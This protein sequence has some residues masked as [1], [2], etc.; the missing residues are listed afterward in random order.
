MDSIRDTYP[1]AV[2]ACPALLELETKHLPGI[3]NQLGH[4]RKV[5]ILD[6]SAVTDSRPPKTLPKDTDPFFGYPI[7]AQPRKIP[8]DKSPWDKTRH[9]WKMCLAIDSEVSFDRKKKSPVRRPVFTFGYIWSDT[10]EP[11]RGEDL[12]YVKSINLPKNVDNIRINPDRHPVDGLQ[13]TWTD[14]KGKKQY[15]YTAEHIRS[16]HLRKYQRILTFEEAIAKIDNKVGRDLVSPDKKIREN[17][18]LIYLLGRTGLHLGNESTKTDIK[19]F[20]VATAL[21][22]HA[23]VKLN[24]NGSKSA[25]LNYIGP[26]GRLIYKTLLDGN[27]AAIIAH[28]KAGKNPDDR[29]FANTTSNDAA[30]YMKDI[31]GGYTPKDFRVYRATLLALGEV[32]KRK[33]VYASSEREFRRW[34]NSAGKIVARQLGTSTRNAV[35]NLISPQVWSAWRQKDWD[36]WVPKSVQ[37]TGD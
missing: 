23:S 5:K 6:D 21:A 11:V 31:S 10:K 15:G 13:A 8:T 12:E 28:Q 27:A 14:R 1:E 2:D 33:G 29:L 32:D 30:M 7:V 25:V 9:I 36:P 18:Q 3:H 26:S 37:V 4:G 34:Q 35:Q 19:S 20:G 16:S 17:A 22:R 24:E